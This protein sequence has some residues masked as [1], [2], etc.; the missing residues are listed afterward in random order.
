MPLTTAATLAMSAV[1]KSI[2]TLKTLR[3]ID[4][5][6][7]AAEYKDTLADLLSDMA[8]LKLRL[9]DLKEENLKLQKIIDGQDQKSEL[10]K[11]F[12]LDKTV[13]GLK[14]EV[15]GFKPGRYCPHCFEP[16]GDMRILVTNSYGGQYCNSCEGNFDASHNWPN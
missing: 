16:N 5:K 3:D 7:Q 14:E 6:M 1:D 4:M 11:K 2:T 9:I 12:V 15:Y 8:E 13:Y 10:R